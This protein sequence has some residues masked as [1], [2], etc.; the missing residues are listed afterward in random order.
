MWSTSARLLRLAPG[1]GRG[2]AG[3]VGLLLLVTATHVGQG[4]LVARV[5]AAVFTGERPGE[6]LA[7]LGGIVA[8]QLARALPLAARDARAHDFICALPDGY[9]TVV[10]ERGLKLSGGER[11][12]VAIARA[13]LKDAPILVLDEAVSSLDAAS[14]REATAAM[15]QARQGRTTLV[16]AHRL[17]TIRSA[18]RVVVLDGGRVAEVGP[19]DEL[20]T[21]DGGYT[22]LLATQ[23]D[24]ARR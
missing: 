20:A 17:S 3:L 11:Q 19:H 24:G 22:R 7:E 15:A 10:G 13:L 1:S 5:L 6:V 8:L 9:D 18:D 14:E 2:V 4:V 23:L 21:R 12:R 16:I